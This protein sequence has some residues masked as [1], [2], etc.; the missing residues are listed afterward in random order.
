MARVELSDGD[1]PEGEGEG[2]Q[3]V[4]EEPGAKDDP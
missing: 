4:S 2:H 1:K 3:K